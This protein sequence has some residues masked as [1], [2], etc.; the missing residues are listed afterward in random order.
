[1]APAVDPRGPV[2]VSYRQ[3]DGWDDAVALAWALRAAGVPVWHDQTDLPPGDT[4]QRLSE[5]LES[6]LSGAVLLVTPEVADSEIVRNL[7][8][9]KLLELAKDATFSLSI[10]S[11]IEKEPGKLDYEA[12]DQLLGFPLGTLREVNQQPVRNRAAL[13]AVA[14]AQAR[15]R[16]T[17]LRPEIDAAGGLATMDVQ[18]RVPPFATAPSDCHLV[19]RLR[20]PKPGDR[21]PQPEGLAEL[22][23]DGLGV[24]LAQRSR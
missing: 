23:L 20:P 18:T 21:R 4:R 7:E 1:V 12:P 9:P 6:G 8:A 24:S 16:M 17:H 13:A 10:A 14:R 5:A 22:G 11:V 19:V 3:S 15:Q 2:L